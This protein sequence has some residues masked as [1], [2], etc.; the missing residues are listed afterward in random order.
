MAWSNS[1]VA[2]A[3]IVGAVVGVVLV[4]AVVFRRKRQPADSLTPSVAPANDADRPR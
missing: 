2:L 4:M 3:A 1:S